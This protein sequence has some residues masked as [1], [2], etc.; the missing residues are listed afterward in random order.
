MREETLRPSVDSYTG[1]VCLAIDGVSICWIAGM[2]TYLTP[3]CQNLSRVRHSG[4]FLTDKVGTLAMPTVAQHRGQ[5][6]MVLR[7]CSHSSMACSGDNVTGTT[8]GHAV[9]ARQR[10]IIIN[11]GAGV[12]LVLVGAVGRLS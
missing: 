8:V 9:F 5:S 6:T 1:L 12:A 10:P 4:I 2:P 3:F 7:Q 11:H